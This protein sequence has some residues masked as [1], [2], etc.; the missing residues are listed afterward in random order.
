MPKFENSQ[1][2]GV[3]R[4]EKNMQT[5]IHINILKNLDLINTLFAVI[6]NTQYFVT[7]KRI[8]L[9]NKF[10]LR[11]KRKLIQREQRAFKA[12]FLC[13]GCRNKT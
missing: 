3:A 6:E 2:N 10:T 5:H 12:H 13:I 11:N 9:L 8:F 7:R 1:L 4:F